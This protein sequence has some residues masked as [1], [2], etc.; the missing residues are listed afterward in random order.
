MAGAQERRR[1]QRAPRGG[2]AVDRYRSGVTGYL[3]VVDAE[4]EVLAAERADAARAW[5]A[6]ASSPPS[7]SSKPSAAAGRISRRA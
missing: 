4:R 3:D 6:N 5:R 1:V 2:L 7:N